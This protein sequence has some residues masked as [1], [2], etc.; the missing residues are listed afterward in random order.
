MIDFNPSNTEIQR[1]LTLIEAGAGTG[2]TYSLVRLVARQ[3]VE[4]EIPLEQILIVTFTKAATAEI[5]SR[6]FEL[7]SQLHDQLEG[8]DT[9]EEIDLAKK[10]R[11][12]ENK[13]LYLKRIKVTLAGFDQA[14]IYTIDGFFQRLQQENAIAI[15][16]PQGL[17]IIT[18]ETPLI[19]QAIN[20][21]WRKKTYP[22]D[23]SEYLKFTTTLSLTP[24]KEF[25]TLV[26]NNPSAILSDEY[27]PNPKLEAD[28]SSLTDF[29]IK[30]RESIDSFINQTPPEG[31]SGGAGKLWS[32]AK[33][34]HLKNLFSDEKQ[35]QLVCYNEN[36]FKHLASLTFSNITDNSWNK[37][38]EGSQQVF[39]E[40]NNLTLFSHL[41]ILL[42]PFEESPVD[43]LF[44]ILVAQATSLI[45]NHLETL[46]KQR[47]IQNHSDITD[48]LYNALKRRD[49]S[50]DVLIRAARNRYKA[51]LI[52]EFQD[53]SPQ[54]CDI[55]TGLFNS[56]NTD[57]TEAPYF[58]IIGDP[59]Q[60]I[61]KFRGAD[62]YS[63][64]STAKLA[65]R[66]YS[67]T[68]NFRSSHEL[69]TA[70]NLFFTQVDDPFFTEGEIKFQAAIADAEPQAETKPA[71]TLKITEDFDEALV[72][73]D[74]SNDVVSLLNSGTAASDIAILV[75][76]GAQA[77]KIFHTL[78]YANVP[79]ALQTTNSVL[80]T[81]DA[82]EF[83][84]LLHS[85]QQPKDQKLLR[86][87][88]LLP[89]MGRGEALTK[90]DHLTI[91]KWCVLQAI[92]EKKGVL[93][94]TRK[95]EKLFPIK[96]NFL[97]FD[98]TTRKFTNFLHLAELLQSVVHLKNLSTSST[99]Q[100]LDNA[101]SSNPSDLSL[102][103][104]DDTILRISCDRDAVQILTQHKSKGLE[105]DHVFL[106]FTLKPTRTRPPSLVYHNENSQVFIASKN[107]A[108][109][110]REQEET[111]DKIRLFYVALTRAKSHCYLYLNPSKDN[112]F[113][114]YLNP[115]DDVNNSDLEGFV[116][117]A[118]GTIQLSEVDSTLKI[119]QYTP[120]T[121]ALEDIACLDLSGI[122][123]S[124]KFRTSSF[125]GIT[126]NVEA[127]ADYDNFSSENTTTDI[128]SKTD[129]E[130]WQQDA[131]WADFQAGASLGLVLHEVLEVID[132]Q[133]TS[134]DDEKIILR[135]CVEKLQQHQ[136]FHKT[137]IPTEKQ[138]YAL[139][140]KL[141]KLIHSWMNHPFEAGLKLSDLSEA[142]R[143]NEPR[144]LLKTE[145]FKLSRFAEYLKLCPP[146]HMPKHYPEQLID[147][148]SFTLN[149]F[150]DGFIDLIFEHDGRYHI[151][152]WKT[153]SIDS[154]SPSYL[155]TKMAHSHYYIQ[156]HIYL[157]A[158]D[159]IL[160]SKLGSSYSPEKH[161]GNVYY[162]FLRGIEL[163]TPYSGIYKAPYNIQ[164]I[165]KLRQLI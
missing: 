155:A 110:E 39:Q 128:E 83:S 164:N 79:C 6:L 33:I 19:D 68:R 51:I 22:L 47:K 70:T 75:K 69:V 49:T 125:T 7:F 159:R 25:I 42:E 29:L 118:K 13:A 1:G 71:F 152:D 92:W 76:S 35:L 122:T 65:N 151:L 40:Q 129:E 115:D 54:Q 20:H 135:L 138:L 123:I 139:S 86:A 84:L 8:I 87:A 131:L 26:R 23:E 119:D 44:S 45:I 143:L 150:L 21:Y 80:Q 120:P 148:K 89:C 134:S 100:W 58:F 30:N 116:A 11:E 94:M 140:I 73:K 121:L 85:I 17:D 28:V 130:H 112:I 90:I 78:Q 156:Y 16:L 14:A 31:S 34:K 154:N 126:R 62:V 158:L 53:T 91:E 108:K 149:G 56:N 132:F 46:K 57:L 95:L 147:V 77:L 109:E 98:I 157:L 2:K 74:L 52:D 141:A 97:R 24:L 15:N 101:L 99:L 137:L 111:A 5:H 136:P 117:L 60:S 106:P 48:S 50:S 66:C 104:S 36:Y 88:M 153:N 12:S 72:A 113:N 63:Y 38:T 27:Q 3:V 163:D 64:I 43:K 105:F 10:W 37:N 145:G 142:Q 146:P 82:K 67:L 102:K 124:Q 41:E 81:P 162:V 96:E 9:E 61:Y 133:P 103:D 161:L 55:F 114:S 107:E 127:V 144:F 32:K 160:S 59:K 165:T 93:A 18:D 4:L